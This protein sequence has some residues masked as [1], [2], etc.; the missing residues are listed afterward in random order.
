MNRIA[1]LRVAALELQASIFRSLPMHVRLAHIL[2]EA[3]GLGEALG[4]Q[5]GA[6]FL[7][8][9]VS[10]M[11][12]PGPKWN[13]AASDPTKTLPVGYFQHE[14]EQ[15]IRGM[16]AKWK[17]ADAVE[18]AVA[19]FLALSVEGLIR[20]DQGSDK[21]RAMG[22]VARVVTNNIIDKL[23]AQKV[24]GQGRLGPAGGEEE[25]PTYFDFE[26]PKAL[27]KFDQYATAKQLLHMKLE[28]AQV[29]PWAPQWLEMALDGYTDMKIIGDPKKGKPSLL[30]KKLGYDPP[31]LPSPRG[32][33]VTM[34]TW[35]VSYKPKIIAKMKAVYER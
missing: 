27:A 17:N 14:A 33:L 1:S 7:R 4:R 34:G 11:P 10:D 31:Y 22:L 8:A 24:R 16:T 28:I 21:R 12:V 3:S 26:D 25:D 23:R 35:S 29:V 20:I 9:G 30:A 18:E 13:P 5:L 19:E 15:F 6:L 32:D 2:V